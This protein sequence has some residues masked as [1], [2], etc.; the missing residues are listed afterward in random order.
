KTDLSAPSIHSTSSLPKWEFNTR[1]PKLISRVWKGI[2][3]CWRAAA[4]H[5]FLSTSARKRGGAPDDEIIETYHALLEHGSPDD[6]QIDLDVPRT[7]SS[8]ILFRKRYSGG[9]RL[10]F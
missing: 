9:Q 8:H 4:W 2:P 3:D 6:V 10:L 1:D 5:S 7:I